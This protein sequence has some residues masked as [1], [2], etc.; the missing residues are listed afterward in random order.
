MSA[1]GKQHFPCL[2]TGIPCLFQGF[3]VFSQGFFSLFTGVSLSFHRGFPSARSARPGISAGAS[4]FQASQIPLH[5]SIIKHVAEFIDPAPVLFDRVQVHIP[6][7]FSSR[8]L[9][10]VFDRELLTVFFSVFSEEF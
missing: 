4:A 8:L 2:F 10:G 1:L 3:P 9:L 6:D 7:L 5:Q